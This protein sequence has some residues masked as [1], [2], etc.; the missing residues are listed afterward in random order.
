M[1]RSLCST[2]GQTHPRY[3]HSMEYRAQRASTKAETKTVVTEI[4]GLAVSQTPWLV[5][6]F[7]HLRL[8]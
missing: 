8:R 6:I 1:G 7:F 3:L 5:G 2:L 4:S